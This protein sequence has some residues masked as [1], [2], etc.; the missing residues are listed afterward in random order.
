MYK[1]PGG[2][3]QATPQGPRSLHFR[4]FRVPHRASLLLSARSWPA[5]RPP[6]SRSPR[7][8]PDDPRA[9]NAERTARGDLHGPEAEE[10]GPHEQVYPATALELVD[11]AEVLLHGLVPL[12]K[13]PRLALRGEHAAR[14]LVERYDIEAYSDC[15]AK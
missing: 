7:Q 10:V 5:G 8:E 1:V 3:P 9:P 14:A 11:K 4:G 12:R 13:K 6:T 2:Y 15:S